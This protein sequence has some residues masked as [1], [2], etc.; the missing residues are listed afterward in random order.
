M[1][2]KPWK[3]F[4]EA[5]NFK[6]TY[7]KLLPLDDPRVRHDFERL[8]AVRAARARTAAAYFRE[9]APRWNEVSAALA[10]TCIF[11]IARSATPARRVV[12]TSSSSSLIGPRSAV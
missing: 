12:S 2:S 10:A 7:L 9:N 6:R 1:L 3:S 4:E 11:H 5:D 8:A